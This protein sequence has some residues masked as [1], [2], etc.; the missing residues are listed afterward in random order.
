MVVEDAIS[1]VQAGAA[2][3]FGLVIGVDRGVGADALRRA[4]A[5]MVVQDLDELLE[6]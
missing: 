4:G 1:G 6:G 2:G 3:D 5:D